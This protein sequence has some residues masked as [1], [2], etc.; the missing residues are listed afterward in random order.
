MKIQ[1]AITERRRTFL[2][3]PEWLSLPWKAREKSKY[4]QFLDSMAL[5]PDV[6][7]DG[8]NI[9]GA[10]VNPAETTPL[11]PISLVAKILGIVNRTWQL[12][13]EFKAFYTEFERENLGQLYWPELSQGTITTA[14]EE[15]LG[16]VFPVAYQFVNMT[17][18]YICMLYWTSNAILWS[19]M[20][21]IYKVIAGVLAMQAALQSPE[22]G[23]TNRSE[24]STTPRFSV[25]MLPPLE[26]RADISTMAKNIA[27]SVEFALLNDNLNPW[28]TRA[29]FPLKVSIESF[30]DS[31][32]C[33]REEKWALAA[34]GKILGSGVRILGHIED[35]KW[36]EHAFLPG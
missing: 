9:L 18:A 20:S 28:T 30:H 8:Y 22:E 3:G 7:A 32:G 1:Q 6:I 24:S 21:Y 14:D 34:M 23:T 11:D 10:V 36:A 4:H 13:A 26:H 35:D 29:V 17:N 5:L 27:Q 19:G 16:K 15:K 12:D 33:E 2:S 25:D 31:L